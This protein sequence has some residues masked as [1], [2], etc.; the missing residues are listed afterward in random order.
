MATRGRKPKPT[1]LHELQGTF[2]ATRHG[3]DRAG[4]PEAL[5]D[6]LS[7]P[8][9]F[10]SEG[11]REAWLYAIRFAPA[12]VLKPIDRNVLLIWC[13]A[14][15]SF[16]RAM[17]AQSILDAQQPRIPML[18]ATRAGMVESPY[19]AIMRNS[20]LMMPR[21]G[22]ELGF[23]PAARPRLAGGGQPEAPAKT[24]VWKQIR[25]LQGGKAVT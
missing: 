9:D 17:A 2:N 4:E 15:D 1:A 21:A 23:S 14:E 8:P 24:S 3:R 12:G 7:E 5:G 19:N 13:Q 22:A 25:V 6:G 10:L 20:A 18:V 11:Q 16:R